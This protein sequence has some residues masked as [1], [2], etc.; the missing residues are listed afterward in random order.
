MREGEWAEL[1]RLARVVRAEAK[2]DNVSLIAAGVAFYALLAIF[3]ALI[4]TVTVYGMVADPDR[5]KEQ[6]ASVT[7]AL[8]AGAGE[9]LTSQLTSVASVGRGG[10]TIGLVI[11]LAATIWAASG[12]VRALLSGLN[13]IYDVEED[14]GFLK[15]ST[16]GLSLTVAGLV[17]AIVA[18]TLVAAFPT[19]LDRMGLEPVAAGVAQGARWF[20]LALL[21]VLALAVLYRVGPNRVQPRFRWVT[22]G[23]LAAV[24]VWVLASLGFSIYVSN[25]GSFNQTYGSIAAVIVLMLWLYLSAYAV[26]L[27]AEIDAI[28][29]RDK[30]VTQTTPGIE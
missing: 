15:R 23:T 25:F 28:R 10:L 9:L 4:A 7:E 17:V 12:G 16:L 20:L 21:V 1:L 18:L 5:I 22:L 13:V 8:P 19:I 11:S 3:P 30:D 24:A 27:G 29:E 6:I 26:L 14:R 2:T